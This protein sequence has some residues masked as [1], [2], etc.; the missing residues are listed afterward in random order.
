M[1]I[2]FLPFKS[3]TKIHVSFYAMYLLTEWKSLLAKWCPR[4]AANRM[5]GTLA[6]AFGLHLDTP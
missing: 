3:S 2:T 4:G 6:R 1:A 5:N